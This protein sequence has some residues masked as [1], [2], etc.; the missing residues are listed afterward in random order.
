MP[1]FALESAANNQAAQWIAR[2]RLGSCGSVCTFCKVVASSV[3]GSAVKSAPA[4]GRNQRNHGSAVLWP[5]PSR[6]LYCGI[7]Q[8]FIDLSRIR[9]S[10]RP[11]GVDQQNQIQRGCVRLKG[12][13]RTDSPSSLTT[14]SSCFKPSKTRPCD[15]TKT[16]TNILVTSLLTEANPERWQRRRTKR[17][18]MSQRS[19]W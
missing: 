17:Q 10:G 11:R 8:I 1:L 7:M 2:I 18:S 12:G 15:F 3:S 6:S 13:N 9:P 19:S 14:K 4:V 5:Y 16:F